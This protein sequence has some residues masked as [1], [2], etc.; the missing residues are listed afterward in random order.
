MKGDILFIY[1]TGSMLV[2]PDL[3]P[4][5]DDSLGKRKLNCT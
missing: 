4:R 1:D 2:L 5:F 3:F